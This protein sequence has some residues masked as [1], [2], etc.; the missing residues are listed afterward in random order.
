ME[1][2]DG[3]KFFNSNR[4]EKKGFENAFRKK[5]RRLVEANN[6]KA[7]LQKVGSI[8]PLIINLLNYFFGI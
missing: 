6:E 5:L 2:A 3:G 8:Y 4:K 1:H 7:D